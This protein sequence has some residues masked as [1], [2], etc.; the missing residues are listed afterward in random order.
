MNFVNNSLNTVL[1]IIVKSLSHY[2][3]IVAQNVVPQ[4]RQL[5]KKQFKKKV[6]E[7]LFA[8]LH[9]EDTYVEAPTLLLKM[10]KY[11]K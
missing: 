1:R 2:C 8:I 5:P 7:I 4:V 11:V 6:R 10:T 3:R 9:A